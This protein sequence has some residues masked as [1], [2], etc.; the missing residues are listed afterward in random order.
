MQLAQLQFSRI[1]NGNITTLL[2]TILEPLDGFHGGI[3]YHAQE[4][5]TPHLVTDTSGS[6]LIVDPAILAP[7]PASGL[8]ILGGLVWL[9]RKKQARRPALRD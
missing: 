5:N 4:N 3:V 9:G 2:L 6:G 7:E 1:I 8:M